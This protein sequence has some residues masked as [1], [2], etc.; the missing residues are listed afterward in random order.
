MDE[1]EGRR[2]TRH[3][4]LFFD[5]RRGFHLREVVEKQ[6]PELPQPPIRPTRRDDGR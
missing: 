5:F 6:K 1:E 3:R 2:P 4:E